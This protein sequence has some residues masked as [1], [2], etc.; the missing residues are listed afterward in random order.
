MRFART[1]FHT[2][3]FFSGAGALELKMSLLLAVRT[4]RHS[5]LVCSYKIAFIFN[6]DGHVHGGRRS[7]CEVS[8]EGLC[9]GGGHLPS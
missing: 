1:A 2:E 8:T 7:R 5:A 4:L 6:E 3:H 9:Y